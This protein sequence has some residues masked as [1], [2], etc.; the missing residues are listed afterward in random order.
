MGL[1]L[2]FSTAYHSQSDGQTERVNQIVQD[3]LR[4]C[5][6]EFKGAWDEYMPLAEFAYNKSYQS[7]IQMAPYEALYGRRCRA[8]IYWDEVGER[9]FLGPDII[10]ETEEKVRLIRERLRTA[11]SRQKSYADNKRRDFHLETGDLV[12][13][14]VSPMKGV[15]RF[16]QGK[17]LSP[18]YIGPF[19]VNR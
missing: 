3:M 2:D 4:S 18:R 1:K 15:K 5:I 10:Q 7:S 16:G 17:K 9:K 8:P 14:K 12:Y 6:L 13:L 19:P 11:Q